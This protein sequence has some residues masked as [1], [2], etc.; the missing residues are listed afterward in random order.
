MILYF[1][2]GKNN[3][4]ENPNRENEY[5]CCCV[6]CLGRVGKESKST[7]KETIKKSSNQDFSSDDL[8]FTKF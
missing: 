5:S 1:G 6:P 4:I 3:S 8:E 7:D 2:Y